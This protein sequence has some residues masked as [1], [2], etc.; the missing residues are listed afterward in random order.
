MHHPCPGDPA[1][2]SCPQGSLLDP[3]EGGSPSAQLLPEP[4]GTVHRELFLTWLYYTK[5]CD[6]QKHRLG[7]AETGRSGGVTVWR[8]CC[9]LADALQALEAGALTALRCSDGVPHVWAP[10]QHPGGRWGCEMV[11]AS[12]NLQPKDPQTFLTVP[13]HFVSS[14]NEIIS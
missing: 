14:C 8:V 5:K 12:M 9:G 3:A 13:S 7:R 11:S 6:G 10:R 4:Q 1:H 2:C